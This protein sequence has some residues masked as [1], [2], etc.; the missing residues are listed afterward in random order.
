MARTGRREIVNLREE[1]D[2]LRKNL[3]ETGDNLRRQVA[4]LEE[5]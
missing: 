5:V 2:N 4:E 3:E 1:G